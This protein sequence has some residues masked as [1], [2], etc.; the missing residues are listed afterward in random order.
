MMPNYVIVVYVG[1]DPGTYMVR[2]HFTFQ[3]QVW[4]AVSVACGLTNGPHA[5]VKQGA[6][7]AGG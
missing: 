7:R 2:I 5:R 1:S 3:N 6:V 4:H